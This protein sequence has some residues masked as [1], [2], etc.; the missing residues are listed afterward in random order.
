MSDGHELHQPLL[1][2]QGHYFKLGLGALV[3][4]RVEVPTG[5]AAVPTGRAILS[6]APRAFVL[7]TR[8]PGHK[9]EG[10]L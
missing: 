7:I 10:W 9:L 5:R 4:G 1:P 6:P 2:A 3:P 8:S